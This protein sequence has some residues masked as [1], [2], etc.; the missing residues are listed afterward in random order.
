MSFSYIIV[1]GKPSINGTS[2]NDLAHCG[3]RL[4]A[5]AA[6]EL[7]NSSS[8]YVRITYNGMER[9]KGPIQLGS[10]EERAVNL[11]RMDLLRLTFLSQTGLALAQKGL[12]Q[13]GFAQNE[14]NVTCQ[15]IM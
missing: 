11:L 6:S 15:T 2:K 12:A 1:F 14:P 10:Q 4:A 7:T 5:A 13:N 3:W 9:K 8:T